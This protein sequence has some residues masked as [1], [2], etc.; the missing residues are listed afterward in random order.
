MFLLKKLIRFL[1]DQ[2]VI[3][4]YNQFRRNI[5]IRKEQG[6]KEKTKPEKTIKQ[7]KK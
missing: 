6:Y 1:E 3:N 4:K 7:Y 2:M 5:C